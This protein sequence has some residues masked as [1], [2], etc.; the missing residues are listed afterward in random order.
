MSIELNGKTYYHTA[1]ACQLAGIS[2]T[3]L[4]RWLKANIIEDVHHTDRRGWRLF[5][6]E[7]LARLK[8]EVSRISPRSSS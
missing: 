3:T 1:E 7:D 8:E 6:D 5:T 2:K 4:F